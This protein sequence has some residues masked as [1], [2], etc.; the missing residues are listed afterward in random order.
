WTPLDYDA[1]LP[2]QG[3]EWGHHLRMIG[4]LGPDASV[5][6]AVQEIARIGH[7][8]VPEFT[9][10]AW[11]NLATGLLVTPLQADLARDVK[12]ALLAVIG[13]VLLVLAI[14]CVNVT[15]LLLARGAQ[16]RGEFA[17]RM[18]LGAGTSRI[19][20]QLLTESIVLGL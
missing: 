10:P 17:M 16:R 5:T 14:A 8:P 1:S 9:R 2:I 15:N 12:P 20:R 11:A 19:T 18:A 3:R 4:R 13:A 7:S 6:G